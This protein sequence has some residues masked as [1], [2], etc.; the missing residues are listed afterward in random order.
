MTR[1]IA[2]RPKAIDDLSDI[3]NYSAETWGTAQAERYLRGL[4][5]SPRTFST[6]PNPTV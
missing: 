2:L 5:T 6:H 3:W 1:Q 4:E